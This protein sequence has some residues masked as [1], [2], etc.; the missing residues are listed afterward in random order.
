MV[1]AADLKVEAV[2]QTFETKVAEATQ[3]WFAVAAMNED[4][5]LNPDTLNALNLTP[6]FWITARVAMRHVQGSAALPPF[7][8]DKGRRSSGRSTSDRLR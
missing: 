4:A 7:A 6:S 8:F 2:L 1:P 3:F 5:K